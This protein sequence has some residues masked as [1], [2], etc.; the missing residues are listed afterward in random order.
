MNSEAIFARGLAICGMDVVAKLPYVCTFRGETFRISGALE[1]GRG[2]N[3]C[4]AFARTPELKYGFVAPI[5]QVRE[6]ARL[7]G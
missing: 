5:D 2:P 7:H 3:R 4:I 1:S 6:S